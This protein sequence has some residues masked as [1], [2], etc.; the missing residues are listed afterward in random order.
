MKTRSLGGLALLFASGL[1]HVAATP[2]DDDVLD[3]LTDTRSA[4]EQWVENRRL[5]AKET[6]DWALAED[7]LRERIDM[8]RDE[9]SGLR[10][11][12]AEAQEDI[13][14]AEAQSSE[15][16]AR[17]D[18]LSEASR[19][20]DE[21]IVA[22]ETRTQALLERVPEPVRERVKPLS[23]RIPKDDEQAAR[24]SL[25]DRF[26][27]VIGILNAVNKAN[28]EISVVSELRTLRDGRQ[29]EVSTL[30]VGIS[31]GYFANPQGTDAG[32]G[33]GDGERWTWTPSVESAAEILQAIAILE[34]ELPAAY[35]PLPVEVR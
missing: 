21:R 25:S 13:A 8:L 34:S 27:N 32:V 31:R 26:A 20:L 18:E 9:I 29:A 23:Q 16:T 10:G 17:R 12:I 28:R 2:A 14:E 22:L 11:R 7:L 35:V 4:L 3:R 24:L 15:L 33:Q 1:V 19:G 6:R 5:I 30:Y